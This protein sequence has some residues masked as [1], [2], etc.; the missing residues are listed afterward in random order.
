MA[1]TKL[2][3]VN[4]RQADLRDA[5]LRSVDLSAADLTGVRLHKAI[6]DPEWQAQLKSW[7]PEG[8]AALREQYTVVNDTVDKWKR[9]SYRLKEKE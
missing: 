3:K 5:I 2:Q 7:Q 1:G 6:V 8:A 4:F 9:P